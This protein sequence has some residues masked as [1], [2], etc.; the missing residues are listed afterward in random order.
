MKL[1]SSQARFSIPLS[2][3]VNDKERLEH[4][5][6][7]KKDQD[8]NFQFE[9]YKSALFIDAKP[10]ENKQQYFALDSDYEINVDQAYNLLAGRAV[11]NSGIWIQLDLNDKDAGNNFRIKE[12]KSDYGYDLDTILK[13]LPIADE[14]NKYIREDLKSKLS[15]GNREPV[16]FLKNGM[17][18]RYFIEANPHFKSVSITDEHSRKV[19]LATATGQQSAES[20]KVKNIV[21]QDDS[22]QRRSSMRILP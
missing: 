1:N 8:G 4:E 20:L 17:Q 2:Y 19:T 14:A 10:V 15:S 6:S 7:F 11:M 9:G 18:Q 21:N 16:T 3:Y 12:F 5:L 22:T 13:A